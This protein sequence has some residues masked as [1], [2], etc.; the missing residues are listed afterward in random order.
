M[1][2]PF[3]SLFNLM[4][5]GAVRTPVLTLVS[6][7]VNSIT[8]SWKMVRGLTYRAFKDESLAADDVESPYTFTGL[9]DAVEYILNVEGY[10]TS[11]ALN[12]TTPA[13][14][15]AGTVALN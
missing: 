1:K 15:V 13:T 3:S 14:L 2:S 4:G 10:A 9:D 8:V 12:V 7:T 5:G 11:D 6:R